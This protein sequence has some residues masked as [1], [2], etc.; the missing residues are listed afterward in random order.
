[1]VTHVHLV[2][3]FAFPHVFE[4]IYSCQVLAFTLIETM[5]QFATARMSSTI[6]RGGIETN[7]LAVFAVN[8][9]YQLCI[10]V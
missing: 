6:L 4:N 10:D 7:S 3:L 8:F 9:V 2:L 5:P 1:M